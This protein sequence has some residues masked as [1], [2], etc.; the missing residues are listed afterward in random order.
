MTKILVIRRDNIGDLICTTPMLIALRAEY[1]DGL[2][3]VLVNSYNIQ[4]IEHNPDVSNV[5]AYIKAKHRAE[6]RSVLSVYWDRVKLIWQLRKKKYD[7][8]ILANGGYSEYPMR[9]A[10]LIKPKSI[11][12]FVPDDMDISRVAI[13]MSLPEEKHVDMHESQYTF[14]LLERMGMKSAVPNL[15]LIADKDV[16]ANLLKSLTDVGF[17]DN[18]LTIGLHISARKKSQRCSS[19]FFNELVSQLNTA[20]PSTQFLIFWAPGDENN[21]QHPGDNQKAEG[22]LE[23]LNGLP[24]FPVQTKEL[25]ELI[26]AVDL[27]DQFICSDGG[28]MHIAAGLAKPIVCFFGDSNAKQ[29]FPWGVPYKL[30]QTDSKEVADISADDALIAFQE[31]QQ[32]LG[33]KSIS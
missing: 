21:K 7:T 27:C 6:G 31:L 11:V 15:K 12:G 29:W 4:A 18:K 1:P 17:V 25:R 28:A 14:K 10:K 20:Y 2:I 22:L 16:K 33:E 19:E 26:S 13:D 24:V 9:F 8:V 23:Q 5:Y 32:K 3:D 30:L